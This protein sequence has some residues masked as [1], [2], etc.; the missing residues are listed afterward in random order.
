MGESVYVRVSM[1]RWPK[2]PL[3]LVW[4]FVGYLPSALPRYEPR[5]QDGDLATRFGPQLVRYGDMWNLDGEVHS[6]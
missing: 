3:L 2:I 5:S 4:K 6:L 1:V